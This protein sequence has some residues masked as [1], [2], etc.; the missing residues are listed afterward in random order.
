VNIELFGCAGGMAEG[1]RRADIMFDLTIDRDPDA[2]ASYEANLGH[3]PV[4]MDVNDFAGM[5]RAGWRPAGSIDLLVADPPCTPWSRAGK[6]LGTE[7][8]RDC[9]EVTCELVALLR[10]RCYL[11]GNVP[12]LQDS[13]SWAVVQRVIGGLARHG[14]CAADHA[15]LDAA[16]Y[17]VPQHRVRPF[18]FGHLDGPCLRWP[19]RTH[20]PAAESLPGMGL[21]P[22]VTVREA[23]ADLPEEE[24]GRPVRM[25]LHH[26]V[27]GV[28]E[29]SI[30]DAPAK[31]IST[32][33]HRRGG[34]MLARDR[35]PPCELD[36]PAHGIPASRPGNGGALL[37]LPD[38]PPARADEP[39]RAIT[40]ARDQALAEWPW[41]P[42]AGDHKRPPS[43]K[44]PQWSRVASTDP[45]RIGSNAVKV[46]WPWD[47]PATTVHAGT[48]QLSPP[49]RSG[50]HGESQSA[51]AI[52]LSERAR[53]RLQGFPDHW[54]WLG[55]SKASRSA[56][57]GMA[58]PPPLAE[59]V[60][61]SVRAQMEASATRE[62]AR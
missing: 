16:N 53:A 44:G 19:M 9:L 1:F 5:F 2:V 30:G 25:R 54:Q 45:D 37:R 55:H 58:M 32:K 49:G 4:Q 52:V 10:P 14:Y 62:A 27:T 31:V 24:I 8:V 22:W 46:T 43:T 3:R 41:F 36:Q 56:M 50:S 35:H 39:H 29:A 40:S 34:S 21:R 23:L 42:P 12:G 59:V 26:P 48:A 33:A 57:I 17:G 61:R 11:I 51:N 15:C 20:G 60:A 38:R 13:T 7:D 18:W 28:L 47:C 6:R